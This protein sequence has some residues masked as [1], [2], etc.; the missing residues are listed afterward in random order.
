MSG[1]LLNAPLFIY[2]V[3]IFFLLD[4]QVFKLFICYIL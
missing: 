2:L 3:Y 1:N 4:I